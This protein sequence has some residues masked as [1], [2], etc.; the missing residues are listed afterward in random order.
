M[1]SVECR[2]DGDHVPAKLA[3][4]R[5]SAGNTS[6]VSCALHGLLKGMCLLAR[7]SGTGA[8]KGYIIFI[9]PSYEKD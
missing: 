9:D 1:L 5:C 6:A 2:N 4:A 3:Q 8:T 7:Y